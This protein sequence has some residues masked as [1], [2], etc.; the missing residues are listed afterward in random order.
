M[1]KWHAERKSKSPVVRRGFWAR[2]SLQGCVSE[3]E[4]QGVC[5]RMKTLGMT[6]NVSLW[7]LV[8]YCASPHQV[9]MV[10]EVC[11]LSSFTR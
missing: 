5:G 2:V 10:Y 3:D 8:Q 4:I 1:R 9:Q 7:H 6:K 11:L